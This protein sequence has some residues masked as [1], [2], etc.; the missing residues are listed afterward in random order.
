MMLQIIIASVIGAFVI[1][2]FIF[3]LINKY[4]KSKWFCNFWG[5]HKE[6]EIIETFDMFLLKGKCPRCNQEVMRDSNGDWF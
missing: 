1:I 5:W 4:S 6:P 3:L 2:M